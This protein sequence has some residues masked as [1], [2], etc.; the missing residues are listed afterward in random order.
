MGSECR[1]SAQDPSGTI[2]AP[3]IERAAVI[4]AGWPTSACHRATVVDKRSNRTMQWSSV[5]GNQPTGLVRGAAS[6]RQGYRRSLAGV[7]QPAHERARTEEIVT[8]KVRNRPPLLRAGDTNLARSLGA[9]AR[10]PMRWNRASVA[11]RDACCRR[12]SDSSA[13]RKVRL[14]SYLCRNTPKDEATGHSLV[15]P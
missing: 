15:T 1:P 11:Q 2:T 3:N 14:V 4:F 8:R 6:H 7:R 10:T 5:S 9:L 13:I 12:R